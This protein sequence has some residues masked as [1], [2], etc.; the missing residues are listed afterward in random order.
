MFY[1][2]REPKFVTFSVISS[3]VASFFTFSVDICFTFSYLLTYRGIFTF[4]GATHSPSPHQARETLAFSL[5]GDSHHSLLPP[6][7]SHSESHP[8]SLC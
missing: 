2:F 7:T 4:D 5:Q 6:G 3:Q 1:I 8:C